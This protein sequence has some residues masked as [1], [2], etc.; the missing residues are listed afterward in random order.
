[1]ISA[2][3][4]FAYNLMD[5][6]DQGAYWFANVDTIYVRF[7]SDHAQYGGDLSLWPEKFTH[8]AAHYGAWRIAPRE[9]KGQIDADMTKALLKARS[10][11]AANETPRRL[12][13][14]SWARARTG[15]TRG[16]RGNNG[17]LLG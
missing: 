13:Q 11:D 3:E 10:A 14:G 16:D 6:E 2:D 12:P 8:Y 5:R 9:L 4:T 1:M 15:G 7:V 17:S